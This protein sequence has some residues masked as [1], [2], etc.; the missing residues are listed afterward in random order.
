MID[1]IPNNLCTAKELGM[2][3]VLIKQNFFNSNSYNYIDIICKNL[4]DAINKINK[5]VL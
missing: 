2:K 4:S 5:G 3:T 1:D